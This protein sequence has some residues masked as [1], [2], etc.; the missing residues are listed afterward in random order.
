MSYVDG[1]LFFFVCVTD[2]RLSCHLAFGRAAGEACRKLVE[3]F[4]AKLQKKERDKV[5]PDR[6]MPMWDESKLRRFP[7][8]C[9]CQLQ[10]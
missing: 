7:G 1:G 5:A 3:L 6:Q 4:L 10:I 9:E 8:F 2:L